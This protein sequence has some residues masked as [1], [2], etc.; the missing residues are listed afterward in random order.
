MN[1]NF[2]VKDP[3][4][5][6]ISQMFQDVKIF[7]NSNHFILGF[8][9]LDLESILLF[10]DKY[11]FNFNLNINKKKSYESDLIMVQGFLFNIAISHKLSKENKINSLQSSHSKQIELTVCGQ[12]FHVIYR[13]KI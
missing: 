2:L 1:R 3:P 6:M 13:F 12:C 10:L 11:L 7:R 5:G 9:A 4:N 8:Q